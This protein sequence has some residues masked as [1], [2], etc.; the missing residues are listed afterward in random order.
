LALQELVK[1]C[2]LL[3]V[4]QA[5]EQIAVLAQA[6]VLAVLLKTQMLFFLLEHLQLTLEQVVPLIYLA[7]DLLRQDFLV[8]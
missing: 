8:Q 1:S 3:A 5:Q 6:V 2:L 7:A 4:L